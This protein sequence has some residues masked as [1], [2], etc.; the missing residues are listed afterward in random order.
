MSGRL[1]NTNVLDISANDVHHKY[2]G[3][4]HYLGYYPK[5]GILRRL[6]DYFK[7]VF[8]REPFERLLSAFKNKFLTGTTSVTSF[9][10]RFGRRIIETYRNRTLIPIPANN[11]GEGVTFKEFVN[12]LIDDKK[13]IQMDKHWELFHRICFPCHIEYDYI[14]HLERIDEDSQFILDSNHISDEIKVPSRR[15]SGYTSQKTNSL[16]EDFYS[17]LDPSTIS[18]LY[19]MYKVDF[20]IFNYTIPAEISALMSTSPIV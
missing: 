2:D 13:S 9:K 1:N 16:M 19:Q 20:D 8:V 4:I 7:F 14:G 15:G 11:T 5:E 6:R 3:L 10:R 17:K 12:Y 18:R